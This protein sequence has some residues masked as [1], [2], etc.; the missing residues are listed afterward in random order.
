MGSPSNSYAGIYAQS[1]PLQSNLSSH[2]PSFVYSSPQVT[3]V[4]LA[5]VW[6]TIEP[7]AG[8]YDWSSLDVEVTQAVASGKKISINIGHQHLEGAGRIGGAAFPNK[9]LGID[10][11]DAN[12][13]PPSTTRDSRSNRADPSYVDVTSPSLN[14]GLASCAVS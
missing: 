2:L 8:V 12:A 10:I 7:N 9:V 5:L 11:L 4:S 6:G 14:A 1:D 3:G 13:F